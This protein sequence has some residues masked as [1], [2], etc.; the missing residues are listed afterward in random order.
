MAKACWRWLTQHD[1]ASIRLYQMNL[2]R[3]SLLSGLS[4][5]VRLLCG[6]LINKVVAI[7]AGPAGFAL[8]SQLQNAFALSSTLSAGA[9]SNGITIMTARHEGDEP[10]QLKFFATAFLAVMVTSLPL[11]L[12]GIIFSYDLASWLLK[13]AGYFYVIIAAAMTIPLF[14]FASMLTAIVTGK[15]DVIS[16]VCINV[17]SSLLIL[18]FTAVMAWFYDLPGALIATATYQGTLFL[19][20]ICWLRSVPWFAF[21][22]FTQSVAKPLAK[23]LFRYVIMA[24]VSGITI[25]LAQFA[26]RSHIINNSGLEH[27]GIWDT[28]NRISILNGSIIAAVLSVYLVPKLASS[29]NDFALFQT[30]A[31]AAKFIM[32]IFILICIILSTFSET[33][34]EILFSKKFTEAGRLLPYQLA[35]DV[36]R[37]FTWFYAHTLITRQKILHYGLIEVVSNIGFVVIAI[38][39]AV[40]WGSFA[41]VI[42]HVVAFGLLA[43][44]CFIRLMFMARPT[45][46]QRR[47]AVLTK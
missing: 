27:A 18:V 29:K 20:A 41:P 34:V 32:P 33:L 13:D 37:V 35:G 43:L 2:A 38:F 36:M 12:L 4:T 8:I 45:D 19:V 1:C 3:I 16:L 42:A 7:T 11:T 40:I 39:G 31:H 21:S 26:V 47:D 25:N 10:Q 5:G 28:V 14:A 22:N 6:L 46:D 30:V 17:I 15:Q 9:M 44:Y 23:D 24:G